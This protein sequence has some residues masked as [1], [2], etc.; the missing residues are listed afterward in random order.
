MCNPIA[1]LVIHSAR[2][3]PAT[4]GRAASDH[5]PAAAYLTNLLID[6]LPLHL[7]D[8]QLVPPPIAV[9]SPTGTTIAL[10]HLVGQADA[11]IHLHQA[12]TAM[13]AAGLAGVHKWGI[14]LP[15]SA[16]VVKS[17]YEPA[18][19]TIYPSLCEVHD[20]Q[21][22]IGTPRQAI[23][24]NLPTGPRFIRL[25]PNLFEKR[26][27]SVEEIR[28]VFRLITQGMS[29]FQIGTTAQTG[30]L[31]MTNKT[32][33]KAA[34]DT[35]PPTATTQHIQIE[36]VVTVAGATARH[37]L[38]LQFNIGFLSGNSQNM[39]EDDITESYLR[40]NVGYTRATNSLLMASALDMAG[41]PGVFQT[42]AVLLTGV[43]TIY[44]SPSYYHFAMSDEIDDREISDEEWDRMTTGAILGSLPLPLALVQVSARRHRNEIAQQHA[45]A[46]GTAMPAD[47]LTN[48]KMARLRLTLTESHRVHPSVWT[49]ESK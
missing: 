1:P 20:R 18:I 29:K 44:R 35:R 26:P 13:E 41:L 7:Q 8:T 5:A 21:W 15:T 39:T 32:E 42:L 3:A 23:P 2:T 36:N 24:T 40:A 16:R 38:I 14:I 34:L 9:H 30:L 27:V 6:T 12:T 37:G 31:V 11:G 43:T 19:A 22:K 46:R 10:L 17:I 25:H 4:T 28:Q 47:R 49:P 48:I 33:V 45:R